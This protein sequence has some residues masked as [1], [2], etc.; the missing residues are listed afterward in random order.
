MKTKTI[1]A[2]LLARLFLIPAAHAEVTLIAIGCSRP[3]Q[4]PWITRATTTIS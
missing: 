2:A 3:A 1:I 4:A